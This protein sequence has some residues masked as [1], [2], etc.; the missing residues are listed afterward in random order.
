Y[1]AVVDELIPD[2]MTLGE[3]QKVLK[4]LLREKVN[5]K[6]RVTI[7]ETLADQSRNTKD[8]ELLT[9]YVRIALARS[10]CNNLVDDDKTIV[11]ATLSPET[12]ELIS[13][14][15]QRSVNGTYPAVDPENTNKIF[16]SIQEVMSNVYFNHNIPVI[17]VSPKIRAPFRKLVEIVYPNLTVLSLNEIPNDIKIKAEGV[18]SIY[19]DEKVYS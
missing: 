6:D 7:L 18:V 17:V 9:E 5:I 10:I 15:L 8:I 4:N 14:N 19:D 13:N 3:I 12:E 16:E 11:V 2:L 1:S